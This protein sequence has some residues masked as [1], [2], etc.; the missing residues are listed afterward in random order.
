MPVRLIAYVR[1]LL[2]FRRVRAEVDD[3]LRFHVD[4]QADAYV[5]RGLSAA[6]A[7]RTALADLGGVTQ[8]TEAVREVRLLRLEPIW[9][10]ARYALRRL[11]REPRFALLAILTLALGI[12]ANTAMFSIMDALIL[13]SLPVPQP[14]RLVNLTPGPDT[15][16]WSY[17]QWAELRDRQ[18]SLA[19]V[20]AW[21]RAESTR[22]AARVSRSPAAAPRTSSM[23]SGSAAASSRC[24]ASH[25]RA[26]G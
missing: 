14:D 17:P 8:A 3:E 18:E 1:G 22:S 26:A 2:H 21:V 9:Q 23:D 5:S 19:G 4:Q 16:A 20:F 15:G 13:R 12:A 10:D 25:L 11:G 7:R 24:S 6:D